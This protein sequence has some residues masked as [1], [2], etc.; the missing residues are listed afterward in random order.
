MFQL[1][2]Q[3][4]KVQDILVEIQPLLE[5]HWEELAVHKDVRKLDPNFDNYLEF[6][7][8]GWLKVF[9]VR[10]N[11]KLI[12]YLVFVLSPNPHYKDWIYAV[13][14]IYYLDPVYRKTGVAEQMFSEAEKWLKGFDVKAITMHEKISHPH[15]RLFDKLGFKPIERI[16]EKVL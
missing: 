15:V 11:T 9:T 3:E 14:D 2:F 16:Y 12:G 7:K 1:T 13:A 10:N 8:S 5:E 6:N 4:E